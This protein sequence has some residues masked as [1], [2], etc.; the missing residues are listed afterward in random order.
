MAYFKV[1]P[2]YF[3]H[4]L[5]E[6]PNFSDFLFEQYYFNIWNQKP[7]WRWNCKIFIN[8]HFWI[9]MTYFLTDKVKN[10]YERERENLK[11]TLN[12]YKSLNFFLRFLFTQNHTVLILGSTVF[13]HTCSVPTIR[14]SLTF[15]W[16]L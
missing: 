14:Y 2:V 4:P 9:I 10:P 3:R 1:F 12:L 5:L 13:R 15:S 7:I 6:K 8:L 16:R 11:K